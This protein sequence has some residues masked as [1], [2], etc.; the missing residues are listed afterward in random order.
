[1][2]KTILVV[3]DEKDI[4]EMLRYNLEKEGYTVQT[5]RDGKDAL[6]QARTIP[7]LILLD[8]MMP[9]MDGWEVCKHLKRNPKTS[10]IPVIFLTAK[11][12]EFDEVL[13]LE[14]GADDYVVKPIAVRTLLARVRSSLRRL[15]VR[16]E[17]TSA[18]EEILRIDKLEINIPNYTATLANK[19]LSLTRREFETLAY[20]VRNRGRVVTRE[21]LL[22][23]VWGEDVRVVLRTVDVHINKIREKLGA[24]GDYVE[25]VKGVGYRIKRND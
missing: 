6:D 10:T 11:G 25:T 19:D 8:V 5:A 4:L 21:V 24:Y 9:E 23:T 22:N 15:D 14:L 16:S 3:D 13:G 1:M 7:H 20:L 17:N 12:T 2:R 18:A